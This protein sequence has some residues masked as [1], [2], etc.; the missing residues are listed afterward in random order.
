M[1]F[2]QRLCGFVYTVSSLFTVFLVL[3]MLTTPVV[4]LARG[5]LVPYANYSQLRWLIRAVFASMIMNRLNEIISYL[6]CG[7][8]TGR[9]DDRSAMWMAICKF[10]HFFST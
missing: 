5:N 4:L 7:Y 2:F 3:S 6:P 9:R 10:F 8:E 1:T